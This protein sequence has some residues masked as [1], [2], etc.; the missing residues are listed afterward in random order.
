M[1]ELG[2]MFSSLSSI[3]NIGSLFSKNIS[4]MTKVLGVGQL[5]GIVSLLFLGGYTGVLVLLLA[6]IRSFIKSADKFNIY[7]MSTIV[8]LQLTIILPLNTEGAIGLLPLFASVSYTIGLYL[9]KEKKDLLLL[10]IVNCASWIPY[11][12]Y[13]LAIPSALTEAVMVAVSVFEL[14]RLRGGVLNVGSDIGV[15]EGQ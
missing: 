15:Q 7:V 4:R 8:V 5:L 11:D 9:C 3:L 6:M 12:I 13:L 14:L 10:I 1:L 2:I